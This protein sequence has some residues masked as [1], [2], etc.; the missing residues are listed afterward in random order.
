MYNSNFHIKKQLK[1]KSISEHPSKNNL[2]SWL[3]KNREFYENLSMPSQDG[4][5]FFFL[6]LKVVVTN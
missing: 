4:T 3:N 2:L 5:E 1:S 6:I